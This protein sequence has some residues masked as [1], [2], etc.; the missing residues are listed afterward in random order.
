MT[1][2]FL[3]IV[4]PNRACV[5]EI[6][7]RAVVNRAIVIPSVVQLNQHVGL[8]SVITDHSHKAALGCFGACER[9]EANWRIPVLDGDAFS[10]G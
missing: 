8:R 7:H 3:I 6:I 2:E 5:D 4:G 9:I 1:S 10:N